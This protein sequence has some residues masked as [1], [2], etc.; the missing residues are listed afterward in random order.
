VLISHFKVPIERKIAQ[1]S[2]KFKE[3]G[4]IFEPDINEERL[5]DY[6]NKLPNE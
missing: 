3:K 4:E 5:E 1:T 2:N 6:L